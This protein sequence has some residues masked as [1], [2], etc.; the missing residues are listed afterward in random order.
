MYFT[1]YEAKK[2]DNSSKDG[3]N[4]ITWDDNGEEITREFVPMEQLINDC[5]PELIDAS[6]ID[7]NSFTDSQIETLKKRMFPS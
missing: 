3:V 1:Y 6:R 7:I 2:P 4:R 5:T